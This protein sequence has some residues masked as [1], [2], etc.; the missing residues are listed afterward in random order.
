M[1][2]NQARCFGALLRVLRTPSPGRSMAVLLM[3][4]FVLLPGAR[5][6]TFVMVRQTGALQAAMKT[7]GRGPHG[8][9]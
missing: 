5:A 8:P 4:A 2:D 9:G 1:T 6:L 3:A 7:E